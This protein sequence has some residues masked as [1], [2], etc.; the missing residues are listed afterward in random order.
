MRRKTLNLRAGRF[1]CNAD[2]TSLTDWDE[3]MSEW[4]RAHWARNGHMHRLNMICCR[5][6]NQQVSVRCVSQ[7]VSRRWLC[8]Y[9]NQSSSVTMRSYWQS[10]VQ[11]VSVQQTTCRHNASVQCSSLSAQCRR[12]STTNRFCLRRRH[13]AVH[14]M[15]TNAQWTLRKFQKK[16]KDIRIHTCTVIE[17]LPY[18]H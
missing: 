15:S 17:H 8:W 5:H 7:S 2:L 6:S 4:D 10:V 1:W 18:R 13:S 14:A 12:P 3:I 9:K 16:F 11:N